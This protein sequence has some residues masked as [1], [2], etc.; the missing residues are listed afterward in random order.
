[1]SLD[2]IGADPSRLILDGLTRTLP[3]AT[4]GWDMPATAGKPRVRLAL[5]RASHPTPVSQY[6]RLRVSAYASQADGVTCD[7]A[8]ALDLSE[9]ACRWILA[10]RH[11]RPLIDASVES[12]PLQTHDDALRQDLAYTVILLTVEAQ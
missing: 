12:G 6:M 2:L 3:E 10:N 11:A 7:W 4:V 1:M 5:D 8:K 9:R